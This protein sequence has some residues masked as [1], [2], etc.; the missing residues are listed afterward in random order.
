MTTKDSP[1][2]VLAG[3]RVLDLGSFITAPYAAMLLAELGADV[4]KVERPGGDPFRAFQGG[5]YASHFQ[6]HNRYKRSLVLDYAKP[7]GRAVL[8][9]LVR[10]AD[11]L[12]MN[13]RPGVEQRL[14][15]DAKQLMEINPGLVHCAIT[16]YGSDGPYAQRPAYDNV[17]QSLAGWLSMFHE[18][19]DARVAG[20]AV[21]DAFTGLFAA[22][23]ILGA[24]VE[25]ARTGRGR[26]VEV[27]MLEATIA[28]ATEPLARLFATGEPVPM[29]SRAASSQSFIVTCSD[30]HRIGLHLSSP[31]KFWLGLIRAIERPDLAAKYPD[32]PTRVRRY[33]EL[34]VDVAAAFATRP[35]D[36]WMPRLEAEDVPFAPERRLEELEDD[37]QV[38]H[39]GV[40]FDMVHPLEGRVKAARRPVRYDGSNDSGTRPPP[41]LGEHS[42]EVLQEAG[43]SNAEIAQ[44]REEGLV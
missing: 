18:G 21:S 13:M 24:L 23:G 6:G 10:Q 16:G 8:E 32:R 26:Q 29:Y 4:V 12:L 38:R 11:V 28:F 9:T 33:D 30:G 19:Q 36:A 35:R 1:A 5:L 15:I 25:R 7:R 43:F 44:L 3:I 37:P 42:S 40:F 17:G 34:A 41:V 27:S 14:G 20:P 39:L 31:E 22:M 2:Q